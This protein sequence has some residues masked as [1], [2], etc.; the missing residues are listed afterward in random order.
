LSKEEIW[1]DE[2]IKYKEV[3]DAYRA[4]KVKRWKG[5]E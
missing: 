5:E 3:I 4:L 2:Y 1:D